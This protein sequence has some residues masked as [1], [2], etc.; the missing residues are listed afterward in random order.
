MV[1]LGMPLVTGINS[2]QSKERL[3]GV[4]FHDSA[5]I[6]AKHGELSRAKCCDPVLRAVI[7]VIVGV[8]ANAMP[9]CE[10]WLLC[11]DAPP[12][13]CPRIWL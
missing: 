3:P 1:F 11:R 9:L 4:V 7:T 10:V 5:G 6:K 2:M 8:P 12:I 13:L